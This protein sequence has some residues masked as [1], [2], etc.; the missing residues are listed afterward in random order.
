[1]S[2]FLSTK[3]KLLHILKA[4]FA[5]LG[6]SFFVGYCLKCE[7]HLLAGEKSFCADCLQ[8][9]LLGDEEFLVLSQGLTKLDDEQLIEAL[10]AINLLDQ[11]PSTLIIY[12]PYYKKYK[13]ILNLFESY[14]FTKIIPWQER[15]VLYLGISSKHFEELKVLASAS[16]VKRFRAIF[17][18]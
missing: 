10:L 12:E 14:P 15:D 17:F 7:T 18:G 11:D 16:E 6:Q 2:H 3:A 9:F 1:M 8:S 4:F 5:K 13:N